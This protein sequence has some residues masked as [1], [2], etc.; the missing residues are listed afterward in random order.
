MEKAALTFKKGD[1]LAV[2]LVCALALV[3]VLALPA[4]RSGGGFAR[5]LQDG[6]VVREVPLSVDQTF[7]IRGDYTNTVTVSDGKIAVTHSDCPTN[8]CVHMGWLRDGG[9]I[10]CLPNRV[11]IRLVGDTDVDMVIH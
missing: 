1:L 11:E 6:V 7:Q 8:D 2:A 3:T 9:S 10:V 4:L 5:I